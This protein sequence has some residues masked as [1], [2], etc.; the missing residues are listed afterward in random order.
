MDI[1]YHEEIRI[2]GF[3]ITNISNKS[4]R[5]QWCRV[6]NQVRAGAQE[7]YHRTLDLD[8]RIKYVHEQLLARIWYSA[9]VF[10]IQA[11]YTRQLNTAIS[12]FIW[13]GATFRVPLSTLQRSKEEG[14]WDLINVEAKS[15]ALFTWRM[16]T[17]GQGRGTITADWL[18]RWKIRH[19]VPN[20]PYPG[21][22]PASLS[23]LRE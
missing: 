1:D 14:G 16:R 4:S 5:D 11:E 22:I 7:A 19:E 12:W 6:T 18:A 8:L 13:R 15:K 3:T 21:S 9:Q 2:L 23:Y 20:P 10:P 17:H